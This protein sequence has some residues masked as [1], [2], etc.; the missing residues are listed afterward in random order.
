MEDLQIDGQGNVYFTGTEFATNGYRDDYM[1]TKLGPDGSL[2]WTQHY[3]AA[4]GWDD[5][6]SMFVDDEGGVFVTGRSQG[7][8]EGTSILTTIKLDQ[9]G[10]QVWYAPY[11]TAQYDVFYPGEIRWDGANN[12][13]VGA[14]KTYPEGRLILLRYSLTTGQMEPEAAPWL[15]AFPNPA[16]GSFVLDLESWSGPVQVTMRDATG[17]TV[18]SRV[19]KGGQRHDMQREAL[20]SGMYELSVSGRDGDAHSRL[21]LE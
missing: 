20:P 13:Y 10:N 15:S 18:A 14:S 1:I 17:R 16:V 6:R 19:L 8:P 2:L 9:Q 4:W 11:T 7:A 12:I 5:A 21:M 3:G